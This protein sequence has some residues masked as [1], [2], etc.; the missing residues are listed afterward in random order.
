MEGNPK[1][2]KVN[3]VEVEKEKVV[4]LTSADLA[5][6]TGESSKKIRDDFLYPLYNCGLVSYLQSI[7]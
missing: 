5:L 7:L 2:Y 6:A 3:D 4:G 1:E